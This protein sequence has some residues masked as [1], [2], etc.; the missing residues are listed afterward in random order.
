MGS[1]VKQRESEHLLDE[2][3]RSFSQE[4]NEHSAAHAD[5]IRPT[6]AHRRQ[7]HHTPPKLLENTNY[8]PFGKGREKKKGKANTNSGGATGRPFPPKH[9]WSGGETYNRRGE[10]I[11][12]ETGAV[13][14]L[15]T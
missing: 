15:E 12:R 5:E 7:R 6:V 8:S 11:T 4:E 1:L 14:G 9:F 10:T 3:R 13:F 2:V